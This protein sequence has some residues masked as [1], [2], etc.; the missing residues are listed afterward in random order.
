MQCA[1]QSTCLSVP[2]CVWLSPTK[3]AISLS[4]M[5]LPW[6]YWTYSIRVVLV[7][8][9]L[10]SV[11]TYTWCTST[12]TSMYTSNIHISTHSVQT[13]PSV[14]FAAGETYYINV[15]TCSHFS[16]PLSI[17]LIASSGRNSQST[18]SKV[19]LSLVHLLH[20]KKLCMVSCGESSYW[21]VRF[22][23]FPILCRQALTFPWTMKNWM[24]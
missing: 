8:L 16:L 13:G 5:R 4:S 21:H 19:P 24:M 1:L 12:H 18:I 2:W 23:T 11:S 14:S 3:T 6:N 15:A 20:L 22:R 17:N 9:L 10:G 7:A